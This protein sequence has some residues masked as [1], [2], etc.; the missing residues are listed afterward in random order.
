MKA[1]ISGGG[2]F[3]RVTNFTDPSERK[4]CSSRQ[5]LDNYINSAVY[6]QNKKKTILFLQ[7]KQYNY[8]V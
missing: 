4:K 7:Y 3:G 2:G 1:G 8:K 5:F 6:S